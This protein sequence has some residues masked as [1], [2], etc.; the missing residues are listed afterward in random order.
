MLFKEIRLSLKLY[1]LSIT[2]KIVQCRL[3]LLHK[4]INN[5]SIS[6]KA[7]Q[8][9]V[10]KLINKTRAKI[11]NN[12]FISIPLYTLFFICLEKNSN[13]SDLNTFIGLVTSFVFSTFYKKLNRYPILWSTYLQKHSITTNLKLTI[14]WIFCNYRCFHFSSEKKKIKYNLFFLDGNKPL[15]PVLNNV[16]LYHPSCLIL[17]TYK[18]SPTRSSSSYS[19]FGLMSTETPLFF[20]LT[21]NGSC[22]GTL[23]MASTFNGA[24]TV[25]LEVLSSNTGLSIEYTGGGDFL[26]FILEKLRITEFFIIILLI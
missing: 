9:F 15:L 17:C 25:L 4:Q 13:S 12:R 20:P 3:I 23:C 14:F 26:I 8:N 6:L 5:F 11:E 2:L 21:F 10:L 19:L 16:P 22:S 18:I 7:F 24:V 1:E